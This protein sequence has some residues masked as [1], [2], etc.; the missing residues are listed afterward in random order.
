ML[1]QCRKKN[2][3]TMNKGAFAEVDPSG[4]AVKITDKYKQWEDFKSI[5]EKKIISFGGWGYS[6]EPET[7]NIL[8]E[9]MNPGNRDTFA[10][11]IAKFLTD[12]NLDGV[13]FDWEYPGVLPPAPKNSMRL[14]LTSLTGNRHS[15]YSTRLGIRRSQLPQIS[16]SHEGKAALW[17]EHVDRCSGI[18]LVP[19]GFSDQ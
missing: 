10:S 6:T 18:L 11:N 5:S 13:D 8:R 2:S 15:R 3:L 14:I 17:E 7:Y 12:N 19:Q 9:A 16:Y 1:Y 4:W